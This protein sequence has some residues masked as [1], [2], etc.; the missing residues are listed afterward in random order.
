MRFC[1]TLVI[2]AA[3]A[4]AM[5]GANVAKAD[6]A[7][8]PRV[9]IVV[10]TDPTIEPCTEVPEGITCFTSNSIQN[11]VTVA[12]ADPGSAGVAPASIS[13]RTSFMSRRLLLQRPCLARSVRYAPGP[14]DRDHSDDSECDL[15]LRLGQFPVG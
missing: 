4:L 13:S 6:G 10:P 2:V 5:V 11:P 7:V 8:D 14:L 12:G 9:K 15:H 3:V 1:K